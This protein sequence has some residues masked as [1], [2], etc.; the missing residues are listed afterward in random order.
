MLASYLQ[1]EELDI[2]KIYLLFGAIVAVMVAMA[3]FRSLGRVKENRQV[4]RSSWRTF[5]KVAQVRGLNAAEVGVLSGVVRRCRVKR[6][7]QVLG[8]IQ[9]FDRCMDRAVERGYIGDHEQAMLEAARTKLVSTARKGWDSHVD[10]RQF[11]RLLD[12]DFELGLYLVTKEGL[13]EELRTTYEEGDAQF[14]RGLES[15]VAQS[16]PTSARVKDLSAGGMAAVLPE[17]EEPRDG[18]YVSL[19][20]KDESAPVNLEGM[21]GRILGLEHVAEQHQTLLHLGFLPYEHELKRQIIQLVHA[22][23]APA[24]GKPGPEGGPRRPRPQATPGASAQPGSRPA[25]TAGQGERSGSGRR[26]PGPAEGGSAGPS[27]SGDHGT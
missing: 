19:T 3:I 4:Q 26:S 11:E 12:C 21:V 8:S 2:T 22:E 24:G 16:E 10:R 25:P 1:F 15:I 7:T 27:A 13:D 5:E 14:R 17:T 18:D 6:P 20:V 9:L 23:E